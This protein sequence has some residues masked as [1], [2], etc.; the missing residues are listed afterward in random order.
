MVDLMLLMHAQACV[1]HTCTNIFSHPGHA[2]IITVLV[3]RSSPIGRVFTSSE[4]AIKAFI[5]RYRVALS[6][7]TEVFIVTG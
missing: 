6:W 4:E 3:C 5:E 7:L 2:G 1:P